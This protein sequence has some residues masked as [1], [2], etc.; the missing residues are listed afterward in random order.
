MESTA[1]FTMAA[2]KLSVQIMAYFLGILIAF[3]RIRIG[4]MCTR[5][6]F[7]SN[8]KRDRSN[9]IE[10]KMED[11]YGKARLFSHF[12]YEANSPPY[13]TVHDSITIPVRTLRSSP[14]V[15]CSVIH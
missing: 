14:N 5:R 9:K 7:L 11:Y 4:M 10:S 2:A 3:A 6:G 15:N 12:W 8:V 1:H 13:H